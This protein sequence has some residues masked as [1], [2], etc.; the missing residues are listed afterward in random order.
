V[1]AT[2]LL[3]QQ[4]QQAA[5]VLKSFD[6]L[7]A[8]EDLTL[9]GIVDQTASVSFL[10]RFQAPSWNVPYLPAPS[11]PS[12]HQIALCMEMQQSLDQRLTI[13]TSQIRLVAIHQREVN[14]RSSYTSLI[15]FFLAKDSFFNLFPFLAFPMIQV[16]S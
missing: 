16:Q 5:V 2:I 6:Q 11:I 8:E 3:Q 9:F 13:L 15:V 1:S 10:P 12:W 4:A 7:F 14:A